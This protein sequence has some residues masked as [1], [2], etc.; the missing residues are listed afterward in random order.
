MLEEHFAAV[1]R[2]A[3]VARPRQRARAIWLLSE[4]A[5]SMMLVHN[6]RRYVR[7]AATAA[8]ELLRSPAR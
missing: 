2:K 8:K 1:L 5:I 4:G 3:G 7:A 6:D